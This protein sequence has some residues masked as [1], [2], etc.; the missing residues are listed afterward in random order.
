MTHHLR[1]I[2]LVKC[3]KHAFFSNKREV[4]VYCYAFLHVLKRDTC[5]KKLKINFFLVS[6]PLVLCPLVS[7]TKMPWLEPCYRTGFFLTENIIMDICPPSSGDASPSFYDNTVM[8]R[9]WLK[10]T[11]F[12]CSGFPHRHDR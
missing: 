5:M 11:E 1:D 3:Q 9:A 2:F 7:C 8:R 10:T 6:C 12:F 4:N